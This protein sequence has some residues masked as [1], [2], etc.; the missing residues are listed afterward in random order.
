M[1]FSSSSHQAVCLYLYKNIGGARLAEGGVSV[2]EHDADRLALYHL[3]VQGIQGAGGWGVGGSDG[4]GGLRWD[5]RRRF[6]G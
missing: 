6:E 5:G 4:M 2:G 1:S 3:E